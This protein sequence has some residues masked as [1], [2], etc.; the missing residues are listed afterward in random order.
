MLLDFEGSELKD[1]NG[2]NVI[3]SSEEVVLPYE[4]SEIEC[5]DDLTRSNCLNI[6]LKYF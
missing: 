6:T 5:Q 4:N 1:P 3:G 2:Q